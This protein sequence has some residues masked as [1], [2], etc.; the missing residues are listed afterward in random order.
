MPLTKKEM[1]RRWYLKYKEKINAKCREY[2][3]LNPEYNKEYRKNNLEYFKNYKQTA[4]CKKMDKLCDWKRRGIIDDD[5]GLLYDYYLTQTHCWICN[6]KY[7][8]TKDRCMD[9][10][11]ETGEPRYICC[12]KCNLVLLRSVDSIR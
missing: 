6:K 7:E 12:V 9:H 3:R 8:T 5:L 10:D 11:H 1:N 2:K 4:K